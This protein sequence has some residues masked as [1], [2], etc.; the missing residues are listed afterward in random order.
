MCLYLAP[1]KPNV[2]NA[3]RSLARYMQKPTDQNYTQLRRLCRYLLGTMDYAAWIPKG[4]DY[5]LLEAY[6]DADHAGC[7]VSRRS[8]SCGV[9]V[10][11]GAVIHCFSRT[12][13]PLS[14][15]S[16]ESEWYAA[17]DVASEGLFLLAVLS[18]V[19]LSTRMVLRIDNSAA[20]CLARRLGVGRI[21]HLDSRTLWLQSAVSRE[22]FT[23][24]KVDGK[25]NLADLGTKNHPGPRLRQLLLMM[26]VKGVHDRNMREEKSCSVIKRQP[27]I[28]EGAIKK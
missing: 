19:S 16:T 22:L 25:K 7:K 17:A 3:A 9:Y 6:S 4:G 28:D 20:L 23:L 5:S 15:S 1:D 13:K 10:V 27:G 26:H 11:G 21:R 12:Q 24:E 2:Q 18:F 8:T 14:L